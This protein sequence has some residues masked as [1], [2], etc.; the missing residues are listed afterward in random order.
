MNAT[1]QAVFSQLAAVPGSQ[2]A[3]AAISSCLGVHKMFKS[4]VQPHTESFKSLNG[5]YPNLRFQLNIHARIHF[6]IFKRLR[7]LQGPPTSPRI[8]VGENTL[9]LVQK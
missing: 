1:Y 7:S 6:S 3:V 5:L 2:E 8:L 9:A 4:F